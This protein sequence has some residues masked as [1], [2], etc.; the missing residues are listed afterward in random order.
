MVQE[1][2]QMLYCCS[3]GE[4]SNPL[5]MRQCDSI[6]GSVATGAVSAVG[7]QREREKWTH[8]FQ[9]CHLVLPPCPSMLR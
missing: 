7:K 2:V 4:G 8:C 9:L 3:G 6:S 5:S 1:I